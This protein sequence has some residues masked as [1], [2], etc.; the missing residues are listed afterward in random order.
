LNVGVI[1]RESSIDLTAIVLPRLHSETARELIR[2]NDA[3]WNS[4]IVEDRTK[5]F[6]SELQIFEGFSNDE[7]SFGVMCA[8]EKWL[9]ALQG[10][11][12]CHAVECLHELAERIHDPD[13]TR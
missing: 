6:L 9:T 10:V 13:S 4:E 2:R 7:V 1:F 12:R 5:L 8:V 3:M 11:E